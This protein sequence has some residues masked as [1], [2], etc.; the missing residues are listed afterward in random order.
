MVYTVFIRHH[1]LQIIVFS[2]E[3][4]YT[5]RGVIYTVNDFLGG[6][7]TFREEDREEC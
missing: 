6:Y 7:S 4:V 3:T 2:A 5:Y 1:P